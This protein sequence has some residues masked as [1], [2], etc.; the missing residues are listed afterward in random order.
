LARKVVEEGLTLKAAAAAFNVSESTARKWVRRFQHEGPA[1]MADRSSRPR[2]SPAQTPVSL[3]AEIEI[4]RR[5]RITGRQIA[6]QLGL[7]KATVHR[8]LKRRG[9]NRMSAIDPPEPPRRYEHGS[10]GALLHLDIK[11]LGPI[12]CVG[13]RIHG[14]RR[15]RTPR[16]GWEF[17]HVAIDD[18]SRLGFSRILPD[19]RHNSAVA[20]LLAAV[21]YYQALGISIARVLTDNG[22]CYRS[23]LFRQA[24]DQLGLRHK[25]TR[26]YRPRTNGKAER[27][28][29]TL[30]RE[31]AYASAYHSSAQREA[32]L[33]T[34]LHRYNWHRPH[35]SLD[36]KPP[37]S[38]L[39]LDQ[40]NV[41]RLH[42]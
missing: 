42:I 8:V 22:G 24:C 27:F 33:P 38:R 13:H 21:Q 18:H 3:T 30:L 11:K 20:F 16:A 1:G 10:P 15:Q 4:L 39:G 26:P 7:S 36:R 25:F 14:D 34:W 29:Q 19:E 23:R 2:A 5:Q 17:V 37:I 40:H 6:Q 12:G 31:W 35:S 41:L 32:H 28:I 9:L